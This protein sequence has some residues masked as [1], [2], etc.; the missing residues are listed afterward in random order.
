MVYNKQKKCHGAFLRIFKGFLHDKPSLYVS[1]ACSVILIVGYALFFSKEETISFPNGGKTLTTFYTDSVDN[2]Y[3]QLHQIIQNDTSVGIQCSLK[4]G[5]MFPYSGVDIAQQNHREVDV[6][7]YNRLEIQVASQNLKH[8]LI[9]LVVKDKHVK[10]TLNRL[11]LRRLVTDLHVDGSKQTLNIPISNFITPD[12]W[13]SLV[14]QSKTDFSDPE[15][16]RL[17]SISIATG[18]TPP[19]NQTCGFTVYQIKFYRDNTCV[20]IVLCLI[21]ILVVI[22]QFAIFYRKSNPQQMSSSIDIHYK[23]IHLE[24][25]L[26][27]G[28]DFLDYI[29]QHFT[30]PELSLTQIS[31][32]TRAS[33]RSISDAISEKFN[34]NVK[35]YINQIRIIE[36]KRLL[37]ESDLNI[38]EIGYKV[39]FNSPANFNRVFK[40]FSEM[41]PSE[42]LQKSNH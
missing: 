17:I 26:N 6:S 22:G 21:Q 27:S 7:M 10:D 13:Y 16:N 24:E 40:T 23:P 33:Q 11:A 42:F 5:F 36:A 30:D 12:W 37:V 4:E 25:K 19:L 35:T 39:G 32:S 31:K 34:C 3:S 1:A 38:S 20:I 14:N 28:Y 29:H 8:L 18:L 15:L 9:Y 2:G 41:S